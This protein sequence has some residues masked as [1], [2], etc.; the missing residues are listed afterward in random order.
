MTKSF[1]EHFEFSMNSVGMPVP[2]GWFDTSKTAASTISA[3][4]T[5]ATSL[6]AKA[7]VTELVIVASVGVK[8][9]AG[10][11]VAKGALVGI[12]GVLAS[13]YI[14]CCIGALIYATQMTLMDN[15]SLA[16]A[17]ISVILNQ[18]GRYG[19]AVPVPMA[20]RIMLA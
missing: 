10:V 20:S 8:Y 18:A 3:L 12:G 9:G 5:A 15:F 11:A 16:D 17:Q 6:G 4:L 7:T 14:G 19:I 1:K 13:F 2:S